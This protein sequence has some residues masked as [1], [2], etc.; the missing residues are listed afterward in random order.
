VISAVPEPDPAREKLLK[1][2]EVAAWLRVPVSWIYG[3]IHAKDLPFSYTKIG[4]YVRIPESGV[5]AYVAA[6]TKQGAA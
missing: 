3:R 5:R 6:Q 4:H 1:P 2:Q